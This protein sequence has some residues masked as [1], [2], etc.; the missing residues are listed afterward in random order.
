MPSL[1]WSGDS[2]LKYGDKIEYI[3]YPHQIPY[4][5]EEMNYQITTHRNNAY[6]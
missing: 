4:K 5:A 1:F 2:V 6:Y 3:T